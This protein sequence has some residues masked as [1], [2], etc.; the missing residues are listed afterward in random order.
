MRLIFLKKRGEGVGRSNYATSGPS[1]KAKRLLRDQ[2]ERH[3]E[4]EREYLCGPSGPG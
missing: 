3:E 1:R 4:C 2:R